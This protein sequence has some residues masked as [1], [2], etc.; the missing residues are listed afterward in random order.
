MWIINFFKTHTVLLIDTNFYKHNQEKFPFLFHWMT[1]QQ[2]RGVV[3]FSLRLVL[4]EDN[5]PC[6]F[7]QRAEWEVLLNLPSPCPQTLLVKR[8]YQ[9]LVWRQRLHP[10]DHF[11][12]RI[13]HR[14]DQNL[15]TAA[16]HILCTYTWEHFV[17]HP[18][19]RSW[20]GVLGTHIR[21]LFKKSCLWDSKKNNA[22]RIFPWNLIA[23][24]W[25]RSLAVSVT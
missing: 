19:V 25:M 2:C 13:Q 8:E 23:F 7:L 22:A 1:C 12:S 5:S 11:P 20:L 18:M 3:L 6:P 14:P 10:T 16:V 9:C 21:W 24:C 17:S 15:V 4:M